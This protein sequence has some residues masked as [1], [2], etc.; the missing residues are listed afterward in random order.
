MTSIKDSQGV[1]DNIPTTLSIASYDLFI[2]TKVIE[3]LSMTDLVII[4]PT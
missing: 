2:P 1:I 4:S 3:S